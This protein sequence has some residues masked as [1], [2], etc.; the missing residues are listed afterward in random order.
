MSKFRIE[1]SSMKDFPWRLEKKTE[2]GYI[3]IGFY[4]TEQDALI[5]QWKCS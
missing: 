2:L 5:L 1:E 3:T 4:K